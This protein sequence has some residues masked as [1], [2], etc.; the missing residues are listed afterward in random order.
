MNHEDEM[1]DLIYSSADKA[2]PYI[3][4]KLKRVGDGR[5][6]KGITAIVKHAAKAGMEAGERAGL[7]KGVCV[8]ILGTLTLVG[9]AKIA[10]DFR[11]KRAE[12]LEELRQ[13]DR[14]LEAEAAA[15][16]EGTRQ[17]EEQGDGEREEG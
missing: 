13:A 14:A 5:M 4:E 6:S 9:A 11:R 17:A 8:G 10:L 12:R 1:M 15:A 16:E 3:T 7:K 2:A